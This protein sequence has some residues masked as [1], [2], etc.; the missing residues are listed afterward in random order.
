MLW[1]QKLVQLY[2]LTDREP[3]AMALG[4]KGISL[5]VWFTTYKVIC[6]LLTLAVIGPDIYHAVIHFQALRE[7]ERTQ[8]HQSLLYLVFTVTFYT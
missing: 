8:T 2:K 6:V 5:I 7:R 4:D 3:T 1:K